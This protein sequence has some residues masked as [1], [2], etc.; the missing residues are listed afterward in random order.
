[1]FDKLDCF[2]RIKSNGDIGYEG[3]ETQLLIDSIVSLGLYHYLFIDL[4]SN[5]DK[6]SIASLK[7]SNLIYWL[8]LDDI[9][10]L[11]KTGILLQEL[12][13]KIG[14]Q[15]YLRQKTKFIANRYIGSFSN[16]YSR[17]DVH[18][19]YFLPY[20]PEWKSMKEAEQILYTSDVFNNELIKI[21][22]NLNHW[23]GGG[24]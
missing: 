4:D 16:D 24:Y 19:D 23:M 22:S 21:T 5:L 11:H 2:S 10:Y 13:K 7:A 3:N 15:Y 1:M 20:I 12:T 9:Q 17:Y 18:F 8:C 14:E 6:R